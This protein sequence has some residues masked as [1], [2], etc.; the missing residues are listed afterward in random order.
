MKPYFCIMMLIGFLFSTSFS[1]A[2]DYPYAPYNEGKMD[3][4]ITGWPLN[5]QAIDYVAKGAY[6]RRPGSESGAQKIEYLPYTP[7]AD[8]SGNPNWYVQVQEKLIK[9]IDQYKKE[10]GTEIDI[11]LVG[12]SITWQWIDIAAP[13]TQYPQKLNDPWKSQFGQYKVF[14]IGVAGDKSQ[15]LLW[16][17]DHGGVQGSE[18]PGLNP[19]LVILAIGHNNMYFSRETGNK[20]AALGVIWSAKN[21]REKFPN[22]DVIVCKI[23][24]NHTPEAA[25]YKDAKLINA[26]LDPLIAELNDPKVHLLPDMWGDMINP[27]GTLVEKYFRADE[28][29]GKKWV[30][31]SLEGYQ[32][33]AEKLKPLVDSILKK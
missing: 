13:Y 23:F 31:L 26:E 28:T 24:P 11:L 3:P 8:G 1:H 33:W 7:Q 17:L 4:Q 27:D 12:D 29:A 10:N 18:A 5:Q 25:F 15:G 14:N 19:K 16:R 30:H 9:V 20:N 22:A 6:L 32:L 2:L 21:L